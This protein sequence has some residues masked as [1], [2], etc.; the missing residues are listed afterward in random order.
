MTRQGRL[1][2][3]PSPP[4]VFGQDYWDAVV[5]FCK[6]R[7]GKL[8]F[9]FSQR[10]NRGE[11]RARVLAD[12]SRHLDQNAVDLRLFFIEQSHQF[13]VLFDGLQGLDKNGLSAGTG[14]VHHALH[15]PFLLDLHRD[16]KA[17]TANR[18]QFVLHRAAFG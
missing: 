2:R 9:Q 16:D 6:T 8:Q 14:A 1:P 3:W 7:F 12:A 15:S 18:D 11:N 4:D 10:L 17:L 5:F 13:V